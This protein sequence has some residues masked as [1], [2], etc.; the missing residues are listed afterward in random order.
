MHPPASPFPCQ[1]LNDTEQTFSLNIGK[2][3]WGFNAPGRMS[4]P[5]LS[6]SRQFRERPASVDGPRPR[7]GNISMG[8][9]DNVSCLVYILLQAS[10]NRKG[11]S[12]KTDLAWQSPCQRLLYKYIPCGGGNFRSILVQM[13]AYP[14]KTAGN[15][16][17]RHPRLGGTTHGVK[18]VQSSRPGPTPFYGTSNSVH[19]TRTL[20]PVLQEGKT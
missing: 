18:L 13:P 4:F 3:L 7:R 8:C 6:C 14:S 2:Y 12:P 17:P 20:S 15:S 5:F 9:I 11:R 19:W 10:Y 16:R 1:S